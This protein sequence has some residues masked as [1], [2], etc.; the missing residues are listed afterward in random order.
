M[1]PNQPNSEFQNELPNSTL[2]LVLGILSLILAF[3]NGL[4][5]LISGII[6]LILAKNGKRLYLETPRFYSKSSYQNLI[7]GRTC[8]IIGIILSILKIILL[9]VLISFLSTF[10]PWDTLFH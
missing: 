6:S 3:F 2:V 7:S 1:E 4:V 8:A 10:I 5:G 9:G